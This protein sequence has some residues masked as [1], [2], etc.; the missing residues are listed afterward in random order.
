M[1]IKNKSLRRGTKIVCTLGPSTSSPGRIKEL[2]LAGMDVVR[3]NFSHGN[4]EMHQRTI[5]AIRRISKQLGREVGILQDLGGPKIRIG[6]LPVPERW[7]EAEQKVILSPVESSDLSIIPVNYPYLIE[8]VAIGDQILVADGLVELKVENKEKDKIL[9]RVIAGGIVQ[10]NKGVNLPSTHLRVNAITE[11]D[12]KDLE[13][14]LKENVDFVALSF[15]RNEHDLEPILNILKTQERRPMLIAKIEKPQAI[16]RFQEI[17]DRVDGI[18]VAR[19]D[20]GVEMPLEKVPIIQ[21]RII[22]EARQ[23]AKPVI[24]AT[25]MLKIGRAHV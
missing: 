18:M 16:E 25:Q 12:K 17:L 6:K 7:L 20:L 15:V 13:L 2:I 21:K 24:T 4:H 11:K 10:S 1:E 8:D 22:Y 19:G 9:C 3:L 5:R 23:A 14:G